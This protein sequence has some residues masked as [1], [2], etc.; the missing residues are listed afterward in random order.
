MGHT[1]VVPNKS[2]LMHS[3]RAGTVYN[4]TTAM[5]DIERSTGTSLR[6]TSGFVD[7]TRWQQRSTAGFV[8]ESLPEVETVSPALRSAILEGKDVI[9]A[10]LLIPHFD[11]SEYSSCAGV[12][13]YQQLLR[14]LSSDPRF[15]RNLTLSEFVTSFNNIV[16]SCVRTWERRMELD[17][18]QFARNTACSPLRV[19]QR[20]PNDLLSCYKL[21]SV[22]TRSILS[23]FQ[24]TN[25]CTTPVLCCCLC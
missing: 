24:F 9:L 16:T 15:N 11:L 8:S 22:D 19:H 13:G 23:V 4:L 25:L 2:D 10:C 18:Y 3:S 1:I 6:A 21:E 17:A 12:Y 7:S 5:E 14:Q 20:C